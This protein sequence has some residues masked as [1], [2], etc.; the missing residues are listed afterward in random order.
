VLRFENEIEIKRPLSEV[1]E[2][3]IQFENIPLWNYY[4]LEVRKV[5]G[6]SSDGESVYHQLRENDEQYFRVKEIVPLEKIAIETLHESSIAFERTM[7][8]HVGKNVTR[9]KD[10][11]KLT[12]GKPKFIEFLAQIKIRHAVSE[13]LQKLKCLLETGSV[14]LQDGRI[15]RI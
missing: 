14:R 4:V 15:I 12:L 10:K 3:L 13:N 2:F 5:S 9:I 8:F 7:I 6:A 11:W 1:F